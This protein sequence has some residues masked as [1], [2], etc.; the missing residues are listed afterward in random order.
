MVYSLFIIRITAIYP[1]DLW[2]NFGD[3][4]FNVRKHHLAK[5]TEVCIGKRYNIMSAIALNDDSWEY[6]CKEWILNTKAIA[7]SFSGY[8]CTIIRKH[9]YY[10]WYFICLTTYERKYF[11]LVYLPCIQ[12]KPE[13]CLCHIPEMWYPIWWVICHLL[14]EQP[15]LNTVARSFYHTLDIN[16]RTRSN[17]NGI[18]EISFIEICAEPILIFV[19]GYP[20]IFNYWYFVS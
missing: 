20:L 13:Q 14:L 17:R 5:F 2:Y 18:T 4:W 7:L 10:T 3:I 15:F 11:A 6:F 9:T 1:L 8:P 12:Y 16:L 19:Q